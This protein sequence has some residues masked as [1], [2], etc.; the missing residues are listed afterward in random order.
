MSYTLILRSFLSYSILLLIVLS[1]KNLFADNYK[2]LISICGMGDDTDSSVGFSSPIF[3]KT[4]THR[5]KQFHIVWF[6]KN[7]WKT[8]KELIL[9]IKELFSNKHTEIKSS[10]QWNLATPVTIIGELE[11]DNGIRRQFGFAQH[12][13]CFKDIDGRSWFFEW[14]MKKL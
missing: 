4:K 11:Y 1:A 8:D 5:I 12:R 10:W 2:D 7:L 3:L 13:I 9:K 14:Q 6:D